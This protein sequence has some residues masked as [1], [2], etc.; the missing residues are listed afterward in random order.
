LL[1]WKARSRLDLLA[2]RWQV[3]PSEAL[4]TQLRAALVD[5]VRAQRDLLLIERE[6]LRARLRKLETEIERLDTDLEARVETRWREFLQDPRRT[7]GKAPDKPAVETES[8][9]K[10]DE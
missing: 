3:E 1:V 4:Q 6:R 9:R 2:A 5:Q 8:R 7:P 10:S